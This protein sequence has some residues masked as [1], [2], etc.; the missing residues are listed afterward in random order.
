MTDRNNKILLALNLMAGLILACFFVHLHYQPDSDI[1]NSAV[2]WHEVSRKGLSSLND[3]RPTP[4]NWYFSVYP[5]NYLVFYIFGSSPF[6]MEL[7]EV[8][9]L[10]LLALFSSMICYQLTKNSK[11]FL[12]IPLLCSLSSFSFTVGY[13]S[14]PASHNLT[15][16]YGLVSIY[17][18]IGKRRDCLT[19]RDFA[20]LL[21]SIA[22]SVSDPWF[23]P[24]FYLP[25]FISS[26]Y[27]SISN[28]KLNIT[29]HCLWLAVAAL[30]F[31]HAIERYFYLPVASFSLGPI[32]QWLNNFYWLMF[33]VGGISNI[34][35]INSKFTYISSSAIF[36]FFI[37]YALYASSIRKDI[38]VFIAMS[39]LGISSSFIIG[40]NVGAEKHARFFVNITYIGLIICFSALI[41]SRVRMFYIFFLLLI[42][43]QLYSHT[44]PERRLLPWSSV[45]VLNTLK[46]H[47][48]DY[49]F[50]PYW[51]AQALAVT[52][53]SDFNVALRPVT[54]EK[55][56]GH[57]ILGGRPQ[58]FDHW[59]SAPLNRKTFIIIMTDVEEC[60]ELQTCLNGV[61]E[62]YGNPDEI[63]NDSNVNIYVY[64]NGLKP[65]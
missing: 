36:L 33:G 55:D 50:G 7:I 62:Q 34:F 20:I 28:K 35:L 19:W 47:N 46:K 5:V 25:M 61:K 57:M 40:S 17:I 37:S 16:L 41:M 42:V 15:N 43:S 48:L 26:I 18:F 44:Q 53:I 2:T 6:V 4:D 60:H 59:Y 63:I 12:L 38:K 13:I 32:S 24:A 23:L 10:F 21:I 52:W 29:S 31:S 22:A 27:W 56:T 64:D 51:G 11:S 39:I 58:T 1:A 3:W 49:G 30:I 45:K 9:Q 65:K 54:F 8:F 14:H